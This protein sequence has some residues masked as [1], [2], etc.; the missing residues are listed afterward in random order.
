M[1]IYE[2]IG[3]S[4]CQTIEM[5]LDYEKYP[6]TFPECT[7]LEM[8][9]LE[10]IIDNTRRHANSKKLSIISKSKSRITARQNPQNSSTSSLPLSPPMS[11]PSTIHES[12]SED[13]ILVY[14]PAHCYRE[15]DDKY[16]FDSDYSGL[17]RGKRMFKKLLKRLFH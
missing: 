14:T 15:D 17:E 4:I 11:P 1:R 3:V 9:K 7:E 5:H 6:K 13:S 16:S 8:N 2:K 10:R 12:D